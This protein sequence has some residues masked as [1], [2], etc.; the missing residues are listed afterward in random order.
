VK[1]APW[2][3]RLVT[4]RPFQELEEKWMALKG[5]QRAVLGTA[6]VIVLG[7]AVIVILAALLA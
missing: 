5:W 6:I 2:K 4:G 3:S 1:S 7:I